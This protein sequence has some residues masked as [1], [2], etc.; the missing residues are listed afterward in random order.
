MTA[1]RCIP[2][3]T[4][5]ADRFRRTGVDD[6]GN[7]LRFVEASSASGF[8][9]RHCL[10]CAEPG[11]TMLLGSYNLPRPLG[12]YWTPSPI[13]LHAQTCARFVSE[14]E[15][16]PIIRSNALVSVRA[17]DDADQCI[18]A[19]GQ[20]CSGAEV[21]APLEHALD[22]PRTAFVNVHTARPGCLLSRVE[23]SH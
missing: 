16:A 21:D 11:E 5:I 10:R 3:E 7:A 20:V 15:V 6:N 4:E 2:I 23:R 17:Y 12:I 14:N 1:F 8:P 18:Y 13:F 19:L 9:C 22:D